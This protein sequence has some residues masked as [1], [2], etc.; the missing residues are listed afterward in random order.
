M[1]VVPLVTGLVLRSRVAPLEAWMLPMAPAV[2]SGYFGFNSL[3]FWLRAAPQRRHTYRRPVWVYAIV[4]AVLASA[5]LLLGGGR[6]LTW[7]PVALP[8]AALAIWLASRRRDRAVAS[9]FA[10]VALAVGIGLAVRFPHSGA[11][12]RDWPATV[13][14]ILVFVALFGYFFGTVL[15][16]K[17]LIRERGQPP[18]RL[19]SL[20]WHLALTALATVAALAGLA[21]AWWVAFFALTALRTWLLSGWDAKH[22]LRP[23][24]IGLLEVGLSVLALIIALFG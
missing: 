16:V 13:P 6:L 19:R 14:N 2:L 15:H 21:S 22:P 9:G 3:T 23:L 11:T 24:Q 1:L 10:T 18:A 20:A 7:L 4:T 8:F 5:V 17:A 12:L